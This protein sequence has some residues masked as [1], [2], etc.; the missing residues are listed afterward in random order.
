MKVDGMVEADHHADFGPADHVLDG[1]SALP[2]V[3]GA[4]ALLQVLGQLVHI[5]GLEGE[6]PQLVD[7]R[8]G[9]DKVAVADVGQ[10]LE[11]RLPATRDF[12]ACPQP[13]ARLLVGHHVAVLVDDLNPVALEG[14]DSD[15]LGFL[16]KA[17]GRR[18]DGLAVRTPR[19]GRRVR[20]LVAGGAAGAFAHEGDGGGEDAAALLAG[21]DG[22]RREGAAVAH[23]L[24]VEKDG[25]LARAGEEEVA[26]ATMHHEV[27]RHGPLPC[28]DT[29]GDHGAT[30]DAPGS[31]G[32]PW[33]SC[34]CVDVLKGV[35]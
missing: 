9:P 20:D 11:V 7:T 35:M 21:L 5:L 27:L 26:V 31:W 1:T 32:V 25:Q 33:L 12:A 2:V 16:V 4:H 23:P 34:V 29:H 8:D 28:G 10:R 13:L 24:D 14:P 6:P 30:V 18:L 17:V 15:Q 19:H 3:H 22:A